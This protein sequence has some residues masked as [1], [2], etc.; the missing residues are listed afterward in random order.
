MP[1]D[2]TKQTKPCACFNAAS[3]TYE[4]GDRLEEGTVVIAVDTAANIA[5]FVPKGIFAGSSAFDTQKDV[6]HQ[7]NERG[8]AGHKDWRRI[9]DI[10][11]ETLVKHW[12]KVAPPS[13]QGELASHFWGASASAFP[14][15]AFVYKNGQDYASPHY[16]E[17]PAQVAVVRTGPA[18]KQDR[19]AR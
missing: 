19:N 6:V 12:H 3:R 5:T 11:A 7:A 13:Q 14:Y 2:D 10:E 8:L 1:K 16:R 4:V 9:T 15:F 17:T 18:Q